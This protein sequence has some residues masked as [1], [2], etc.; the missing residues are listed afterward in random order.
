MGDGAMWHASKKYDHS[1]NRDIELVARSRSPTT[2]TSRKTQKEEEVMPERSIIYQRSIIYPHD[3][4]FEW[5]T[6]EAYLAH[7]GKID[8]NKPPC[9]ASAMFD[10]MS[11][12]AHNFPRVNDHGEVEV[13]ICVLNEGVPFR[14]NVF[15][16]GS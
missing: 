3:T 12:K 10:Y 7:N 2:R 5:M 13:R 14:R 6:K 8:P 1:V 9:Y 11:K 4:H 15:V 16:P